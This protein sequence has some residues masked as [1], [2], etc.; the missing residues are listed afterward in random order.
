MGLRALPS[1]PI[2]ETAS[3][4]C[5]DGWF[6]S[7]RFLVDRLRTRAPSHRHILDTPSRSWVPEAPPP[8]CPK[9][10][11]SY[12]TVG[13]GRR[14]DIGIPRLTPPREGAQKSSFRGPK[15][16]SPVL[17]SSEC[18]IKL[19]ESDAAV[20]RGRSRA[21]IGSVAAVARGV[22][23]GVGAVWFWVMAG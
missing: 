1:F 17:T 15:P 22:A 4:G 12:G 21:S 14:D 16:C 23:A 9:T 3:P 20:R 7:S 2:L 10:L 5:T 6:D 11:L 18:S 13:G 8:V 19:L